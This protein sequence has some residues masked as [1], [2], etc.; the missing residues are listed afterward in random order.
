[1]CFKCWFGSLVLFPEW[2]S[3]SNYVDNCCQFCFW[4]ATCHT[5]MA[6]WVLYISCNCFYLCKVC[7]KIKWMSSG[8]TQQDSN[9]NATCRS[10]LSDC[11]RHRL[12]GSV[13]PAGEDGSLQC[14]LRATA[15]TRCCSAGGRLQTGLELLVFHAIVLPCV[16]RWGKVE[17]IVFLKDNVFMPPSYVQRKRIPITLLLS[18]ALWGRW[19]RLAWSSCVGQRGS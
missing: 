10:V 1:M 7:I 15:G 14:H 19:R 2:C 8:S 17:F 9:F 18:L 12:M 3:A 5:A 16:S 4:K 13:F 6:C 11:A